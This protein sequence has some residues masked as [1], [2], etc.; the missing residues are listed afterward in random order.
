MGVA[1][2]ADCPLLMPDVP[3]IA[4]ECGF[5]GDGNVPTI[6]RPFPPL[7]TVSP[8]SP[9]FSATFPEKTVEIAAGMAWDAVFISA[10]NDHPF[11]SF[12]ATLK[13]V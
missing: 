6:N 8:F 4:V 12:I 11:N 7:C 5:W 9:Q 3:P 2:A 1:F 13:G 10:T